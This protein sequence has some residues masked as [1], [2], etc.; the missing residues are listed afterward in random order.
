MKTKNPKNPAILSKNSGI[1]A[2]SRKSMASQG[3]LDLVNFFALAYE[4]GKNPKLE[5]RY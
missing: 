4:N 5:N 2:T 1:V 3:H